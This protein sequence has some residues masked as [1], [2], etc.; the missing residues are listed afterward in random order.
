LRP[1]EI[2]YWGSSC[3]MQHVIF[4]SGPIFAWGVWTVVKYLSSVAL[5]LLACLL[6]ASIV[7]A[8][9]G[10][11]QVFAVLLVGFCLFDSSSNSKAN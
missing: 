10:F 5:L 4:I 6:V 8:A 3:E 1:Q 9:F 11:T 2:K 7:M